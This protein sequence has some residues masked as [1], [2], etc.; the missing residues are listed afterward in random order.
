MKRRENK[1][2]GEQ[3]KFSYI[4]TSRLTSSFETDRHS[5]F[6]MLTLWSPADFMRPLFAERLQRTGYEFRPCHLQLNLQFL[7]HPDV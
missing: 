2:V 3:D 1:G 7:C 6:G 4:H 5:S